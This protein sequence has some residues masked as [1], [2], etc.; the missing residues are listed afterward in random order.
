MRC[1]PA[2]KVVAGS[3]GATKYEGIPFTQNLVAVIAS[4]SLRDDAG[5]NPPCRKNMALLRFNDTWPRRGLHIIT[6]STVSIS[7]LYWLQTNVKHTFTFY[8]FPRAVGYSVRPHQ[9]R[10]SQSKLKGHDFMVQSDRTLPT[11]YKSAMRL[12]G[13]LAS[14]PYFCSDS[15]ARQYGGAAEQA[16]PDL[17]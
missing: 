2:G 1:Y 11:A 8:L 14:L 15:G 6:T 10:C 3:T 4:N 7:W 9:S 13:V 12:S 17:R 16:G 5:S